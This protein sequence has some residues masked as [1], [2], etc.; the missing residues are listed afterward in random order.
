MFGIRYIKAAPHVHIMQYRGGRIKR[1][2]QGLSFFYA[3]PFSSLVAVPVTSQDIP[4]IFNEVTGDFQEISVQG[5]V[6]YR[7]QDP[8]RLSQ[9]MD[10]TLDRRGAHY[11]AEDPA[12]LPQRV[13]QII[14]VCMR[15][16]FSKMSLREALSSSEVLVDETIEALGS[17]PELRSMGIAVLGLSILAIKPNPETARA[18]EAHIREELLRE[19]DEAVYSRR[20]AAVEQERAIRENELETEIAVERKQRQ[21]REEKIEAERSIKRK[22]HQIR[23]EEMTAKIE[24]EERNKELVERWAENKRAG[25]DAE[26]YGI[27]A[28]LKALEGTDRHVL[29]AL[30][31]VGMDP[32]KLVAMGFRDLAE[33]TGKIGQLNISPDLLRE[34]MALEK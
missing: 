9:M 23:K 17:S 25:A 22:K 11:T 24:L 29:Q 6:T 4:F 13:L 8:H 12:K 5:Q 19:A 30:V 10:F 27:A 28:S 16:R 33:S 3:S 14:Q 7:V 1:E 31:S 2:G 32:G 26:A 15:I 34:L 18:L 20:N 21:V